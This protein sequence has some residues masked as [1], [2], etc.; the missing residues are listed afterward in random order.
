LFVSISEAI[1]CQ[2]RHHNDLRCARGDNK[3][4]SFTIRNTFKTVL[5][6]FYLS[7]NSRETF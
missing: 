7:R 3:L 4:N 2:D 5:K 6:L 1:G